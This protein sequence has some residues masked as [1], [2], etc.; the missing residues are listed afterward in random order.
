MKKWGI[1]DVARR[2]GQ[3]RKP[4]EAG[5]GQNWPPHSAGALSTLSSKPG[6]PRH[7]R[8]RNPMVCPTGWTQPRGGVQRGDAEHHGTHFVARAEDRMLL[9]SVGLGFPGHLRGDPWIDL[10]ERRIFL[11]FEALQQIVSEETVGIFR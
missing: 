7:D 8:P 4:A 3:H 10:I 1:L 9:P 6:L 5:C 11:L 2:A